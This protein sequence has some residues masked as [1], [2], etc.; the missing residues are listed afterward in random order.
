MTN[1]LNYI[2]KNKVIAPIGE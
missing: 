2:V 1:F